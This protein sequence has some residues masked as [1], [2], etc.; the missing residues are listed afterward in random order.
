MLLESNILTGENI[1]LITKQILLPLENDQE[2]ILMY[3]NF[4]ARKTAKKL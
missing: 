4:A 2:N 3:K 1:T